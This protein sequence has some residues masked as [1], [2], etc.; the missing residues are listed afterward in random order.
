MAIAHVVYVVPTF[1]SPL[2]TVQ[3][4]LTMSLGDASVANTEMRIAPDIQVPNSAGSPKIKD[5]IIAEAAGGFHT[6]HIS[7]T[8]IVT[9][10][11]A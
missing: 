9:S 4:K 10:D 11:T 2:G 6:R 1:I 5:Y 8:M 7:N 3:D